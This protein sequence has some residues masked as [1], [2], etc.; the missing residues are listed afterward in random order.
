MVINMKEFDCGQMRLARRARKMKQ[1][2][3]ADILHVSAASIANMENGRVRT[4]AEDLALL[5]DAYDVDVAVFFKE[6][7]NDHEC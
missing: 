7:G 4:S 3:A 2:D 5:A 6:R 1:Q